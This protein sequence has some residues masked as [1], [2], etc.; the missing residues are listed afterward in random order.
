MKK[1]LIFQINFFHKLY[2]TQKLSRFLIEYFF[3]KN[4]NDT[5]LIL[6]D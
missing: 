2:Q 4:L 6:T 3:N 5:V 1:I